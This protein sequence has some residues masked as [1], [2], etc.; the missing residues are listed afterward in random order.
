MPRCQAR[1]AVMPAA[2]CEG[3]DRKRP[4]HVLGVD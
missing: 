3:R 4:W 1:R 2:G